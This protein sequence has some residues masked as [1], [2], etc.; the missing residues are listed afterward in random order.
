[1]NILVS[2]KYVCYVFLLAMPWYWIESYVLVHAQY[3][4]ISLYSAAFQAIKLFML[5]VPLCLWF[6]HYGLSK[7]RSKYFYI[8]T[9]ILCFYLLLGIK[10]GYDRMNIILSIKNI[11][12][13]FYV[14]IF[15]YAINNRMPAHLSIFLVITI[16]IS[17]LMNVGYSIYINL[18]YTGD[19]TDFYFYDLYN[20]KGMFVIWNFIRDGSVR[21]FGLVGSKLTLSQLYIVP[22]LISLF[23]AIYLNDLKAK[24]LA[25]IVFCILMYGL[26]ITATR[27]PYLAIF[28]S[29][30]VYSFFCCFKITKIRFFVIT[31]VLYAFSIYLVLLL[32][33]AG[34]GD[35]SSKARIPMLL[36]FFNELLDK[37][38]GHGIGSTG[39]ASTTYPF[40]FESS[41]ATVFMDLGIIGGLFYFGMIISF[42]FQ[43]IRAANLTNLPIL[44]SLLTASG[45]SLLSLFFLTNFTNIYDSSLFVYTIVTIFALNVHIVPVEKLNQG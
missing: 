2:N 10:E 20:S 9:I 37:P 14:L 16:F 23:L 27:N 22:I 29:F 31:L 35:E 43:M 15:C 4:G 24:A 28:F 21:A 12:F 18:T 45:Y 1:M 26:W 41:L 30:V 33:D 19:P 42:S 39:V 17:A 34:V 6:Y 7:Q 3:S 44:K 38:F 25:L 8:Y 40:F 13:W 36:S 32:S 11:Y 5:A